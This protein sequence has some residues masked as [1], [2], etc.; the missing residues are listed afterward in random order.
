LDDEGTNNNPDGQFGLAGYDGTRRQSYD[1]CG[2]TAGSQVVDGWGQEVK[3]S[4]RCRAC[5]H[6]LGSGVLQ[7]ELGALPAVIAVAVFQER[8]L[9]DERLGY[10]VALL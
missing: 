4:Y 1:E 5:P 3:W 8:A 7:G 10:L 2:D 9:Y 6:L